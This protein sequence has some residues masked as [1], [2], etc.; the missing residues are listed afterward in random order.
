MDNVAE[1][2][3]IFLTTHSYS[4][5]WMTPWGYTFDNHTNYER[6][7]CFAFTVNT[8]GMKPTETPWLS[9]LYIQSI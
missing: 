1:G 6:M 7:V 3:L 4:Q 5:L 2:G 8:I 9:M